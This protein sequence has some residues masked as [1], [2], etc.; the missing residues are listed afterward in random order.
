MLLQVCIGLAFDTSYVF[1]TELFPTV[2]RRFKIVLLKS[3]NDYILVL[4]LP[5]A[6]P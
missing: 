3:F 4:A 5:A 2:V 1:T 6:L